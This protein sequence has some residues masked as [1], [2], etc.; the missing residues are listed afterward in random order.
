MLVVALREQSFKLKSRTVEFANTKD[1]ARRIITAMTFQH[2]FREL[3]SKKQM[4]VVHIQQR[5]RTWN[6]RKYFFE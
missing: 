2:A 3:K 4:V 5:L 6:I 1:E